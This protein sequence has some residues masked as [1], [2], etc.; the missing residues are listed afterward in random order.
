LEGGVP[1]NLGAD[2]RYITQYMEHLAIPAN[3]RQQADRGLTAA[4]Q[5]GADLFMNEP[6]LGSLTCNSC[7]TLP[8]GSAGEVVDNLGGGYAPATVAPSLRGITDKLAAPFQVGGPFGE[9]TELGAGLGHGGALASIQAVL[10]QQLPPPQVGQRFDVTP[11]EAD[12]LATFLAAF[13]TGLAPAAAWQITAHQD[14][15]GSFV[16]DQLA[17]LVAEA[18]K[19]NCDLVYRFGPELWQGQPTWFTG[20]YDPGSGRFRQASVTLPPLLTSNLMAKAAGG[21][22]VTFLGVP[23]QSG[24]PMGVDRDNDK[25]LDLDERLAGTNP[26]D[27]DTDDDGYHDGYETQWGMN[28]LVPNAS[29]PDQQAPQLLGPV[30]VVYTTTHAV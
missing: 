10:L 26:E 15:A 18:A 21:M 9:R 29:S 16:N 8:L 30:R 6:V 12:Q 28:P 5:V 7:H 11:A 24:W 27:E 22:P 4:Q 19:G 14:N 23:R 2:F 13:D 17:F 1:K 20:L 25:L 3:P